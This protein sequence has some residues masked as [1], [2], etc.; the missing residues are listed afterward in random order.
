MSS[1]DAVHGAA[2]EMRS[3]T[4]RVAFIARSR[5]TNAFLAIVHPIRKVQACSPV[6][7]GRAETC[8]SPD[9]PIRSRCQTT[10]PPMARPTVQVIHEHPCAFAP[11]LRSDRLQAP[12]SMAVAGVLPRRGERRHVLHDMASLL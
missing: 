8:A 3:R 10:L 2:M 12:R 11:R 5:L 4:V 6:P 1:H 7:L 9:R